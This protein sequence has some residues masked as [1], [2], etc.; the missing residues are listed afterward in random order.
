LK[1]RVDERRGRTEGQNKQEKHKARKK[2]KRSS[3]VNRS[4]SVPKL[5]LSS[6]NSPGRGSGYSP[7][8]S[9]TPHEIKPLSARI[10][11]TENDDDSIGDSPLSSARDRPSF[12][13][14]LLSGKKK[15]EPKE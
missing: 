6:P 11:G 1:T 5:Q 10:P 4:S 3:V 15:K 9:Q 12:L 8:R 13:R 14:R 2:N 7:G